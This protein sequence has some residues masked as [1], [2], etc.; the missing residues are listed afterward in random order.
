MRW[1]TAE[2]QHR[3]WID[4]QAGKVQRGLSVLEAAPP[5]IGRTPD[6]GAIAVACALGYLDLRFEGAWRAGHPDMVNWLAAFTAAIPSF[7]TTRAH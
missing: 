3:P 6:V 1:R 5:A 2:F 7:D 4:H